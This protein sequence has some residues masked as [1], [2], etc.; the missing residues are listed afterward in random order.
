M[1]VLDNSVL[2]AWI[3]ETQATPYTEAVFVRAREETVMA[4]AILHVEAANA[5][6]SLW[7]RR[8]L[9]LDQAMGLVDA[10][11]TFDVVLDTEQ[12]APGLMLSLAA[13]FNLSAYDA[14]YL[15]LAMRKGA[16]IATQDEQLARAARAAGIGMV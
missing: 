3:V 8:K 1:F 9:T 16:P 5:L 12:P 6:R 2:M 11:L 4:P 15:E 13:R 14:L 7:A 10:A